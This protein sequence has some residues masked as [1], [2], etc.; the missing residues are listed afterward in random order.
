VL[1][2]GQAADTG[3]CAGSIQLEPFRRH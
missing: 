3:T 1:V 2:G